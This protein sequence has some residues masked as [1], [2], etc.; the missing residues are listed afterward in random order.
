MFFQISNL[1]LFTVKS[2]CRQKNKRKKKCTKRGPLEPWRAPP[3]GVRARSPALPSPLPP[4][5]PP[6]RA[7]EPRHVPWGLRRPQTIP[8]SPGPAPQVGFQFLQE[9]PW[10]PKPPPTPRCALPS[11]L[12]PSTWGSGVPQGLRETRTLFQAALLPPGPRASRP[13]SAPTCPQGP[14]VLRALARASVG[15]SVPSWP[16][17]VCRAPKSPPA[18][19]PA[20]TP[21]AVCLEFQLRD[22]PRWAVCAPT[23]RP[24]RHPAAGGSAGR[25]VGA[26]TMPSPL[27]HPSSTMV[28]QRRA[29]REQQP[30]R[31][32]PEGDPPPARRRERS[33]VTASPRNTRSHKGAPCP[34][35]PAGQRSPHGPHSPGHPQTCRKTGSR[36]SCPAPCLPAPPP[37]GSGQGLPTLTTASKRP[38]VLANCP[39]SPGSHVSRGPPPVGPRAGSQAQGPKGTP[40]AGI[41]VQR[42]PQ[43]RP[44]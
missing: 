29:V 25:R 40:R 35:R 26:G 1:L 18:P 27:G 16:V 4:S 21:L 38:S 30:V 20:H 9:P 5:A 19:A 11:A 12:H 42:R 44:V 7:A 41:S 36:R 31:G 32:W 15:L 28:P 2:S 33:R 24:A 10:T 39:T 37:E 14:R 3:G 8:I 6:N 23:P 22:G 17:C 43:P 13:I 34:S